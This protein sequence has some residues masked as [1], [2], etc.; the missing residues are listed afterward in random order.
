MIN[1]SLGGKPIPFLAEE[2]VT[3][4]DTMAFAVHPDCSQLNHPKFPTVKTLN[5][6]TPKRP[7]CQAL[8]LLVSEKG[9][10]LIILI[11]DKW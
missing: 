9:F 2:G 10:D 1:P 11:V 7:I 4:S 8:V 5:L 6:Q 3:D